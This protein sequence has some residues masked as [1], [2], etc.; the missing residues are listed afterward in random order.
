MDLPE[1]EDEGSLVYRPKVE[2]Q[3]K[4]KVW[5]HIY[6]I[7]GNQTHPPK[8]NPNGSVMSKNDGRFRSYNYHK[9]LFSKYKECN[10]KTLDFDLLRSFG[11]NE[12]FERVYNR[13]STRE[14]MIQKEWDV[15]YPK[16]AF[17]HNALLKEKKIKF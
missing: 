12:E 1:D 17:K 4:D 6:N 2:W 9:I 14:R 3:S 7:L 5:N 15:K 16:S 8:F 10:G 13:I 11:E